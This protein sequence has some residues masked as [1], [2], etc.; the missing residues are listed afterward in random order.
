MGSK[1]RKKRTAKNTKVYKK[2][3]RRIHKKRK[4]AASAWSFSK[5]VIL[6]VLGNAMLMMWCSY[7]LAWFDKIAIA[8]TLSS[9][10]AQVIVGT[11]IGYLCTKT[12]ENVSKYGSRL[13]GTTA[14]QQPPIQIIEL[15]E[16]EGCHT[17]EESTKTM[18]PEN[19]EE[20]L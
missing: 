4:A 7:V 3:V 9:T 15:K 12:I 1:K 16:E 13:N 18:S 19:T 10:V 2:A 5:V 11:V 20:I 17:N 6:V 14:E 8:E